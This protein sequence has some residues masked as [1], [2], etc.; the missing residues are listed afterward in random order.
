MSAVAEQQPR[1][2]QPAR[3]PAARIFRYSEY[4]DVGDG[5]VEC[6]HSRDGQ[7]EDPEHFHAWCRL[8]NPYQEQD[9]RDKA[10]AAKARRLRMLRDPESD[11]S[12]V[13]E[14]ELSKLNDPAYADIL[15]DE[16]LTEEWAES[17]VQAEKEVG[18]REEYEHHEQDREEFLRL[19]AIE[20]DLSEEERSDEYKSLEKHVQGYLDAVRARTEELQG[21]KRDQFAQRPFDVLYGLVR[22]RRIDALG[23]R[24]FI[25]AYNEWMIFAGTFRPEIEGHAVKS[26]RPLW[27]DIG[28]K[29]RPE[30]GT[31]YAESPEV[32]AA[33]TALFNAL[34]M[35][36][37]KGS[38]GN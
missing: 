36:Q 14:S 25:D 35:S 32:I 16:L 21:P 5:A 30:P 34:R 20:G 27:A 4:I 33:L 3:E 15:V 19:N 22:D 8:P 10:M 31:M 2:E 24:A 18:Q 1:E 37:R 11:A 29:L 7:C 28:S 38:L 12:V 9:I 13:L 6:E 17:Y 26:H 23:D